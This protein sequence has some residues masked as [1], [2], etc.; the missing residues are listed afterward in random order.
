MVDTRLAQLEA[1]V[2]GLTQ[3]VY[4]LE[5]QVFDQG[6]QPTGA[7][8]PPA[9]YSAPPWSSPAPAPPGVPPRATPNR[10]PGRGWPA[11][12]VT[13]SRLLATGGAI[14]LLLGLGYLVRFAVAQGWLGPGTR[15]LLALTG[16]A[17]L[18]VVGLRLERTAATKVVGQICAATAAAGGYVAVVAA[19]VGYEL[20]SAAVGLVGAVTIAAALAV[21]GVTT[22]SQAVAAVGVGGALAGPAF[23][24]AAPDLLGL[25]FL[26]IAIVAGV[27]VAVAQRWVAVTVLAFMLAWPQIASI[28]LSGTPERVTLML[29]AIAAGAFLIAG[30]LHARGL[31]WTNAALP[32]GIVALNGMLLGSLGWAVLSHIS[33][34]EGPDPQRVAAGAWLAGVALLHLGVA[35]V[36]SRRLYD[37]PVGVAIAMVGLVLADL[38]L[39]D[40]ADGYGVAV[41]LCVGLAGAAACIHLEWLRSA[42]RAT[43]VAQVVVVVLHALTTVIGLAPAGSAEAMATAAAYCALAVALAVLL[44]PVSR[45][46]AAGTGAAVLI[47]PAV[48]LL[49]SEAPLSA[50]LSGTEHLGGA[51]AICAALAAGCIGLGVLA[52]RGFFVAA[53]TAINYAASLAAVAMDPVGVGRVALTGLWSAGGGIALVAGR[54]YQRRDVRRG[55]AALLTAAV[56]KAA[57][58]DTV[59]LDGTHRAVALLLC[60]TA[61][62]ATAVAEA[63]SSDGDRSATALR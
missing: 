22:R 4:R 10:A 54:L 17:A 7:V 1:T 16:S 30:V 59:M 33:F 44:R 27:A 43:V 20:V 39:A 8:R 25:T 48:R 53:V 61:L 38:A 2:R 21:R 55:G 58:V 37:P 23:V 40:L 32:A 24:G 41:G 14:A 62:V 6:P 45:M 28:A 50:L 52:H 12:E 3:R 9:P 56:A 35:G 34:W 36:V 5:G 57:L 13:P 60:G 19:A 46:L 26:V 47:V 51:V 31:P 15:I 42:A 63:R 18:G 49:T 11:V 29:A